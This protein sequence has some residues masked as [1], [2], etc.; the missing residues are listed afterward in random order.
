MFDVGTSPSYIPYFFH[1]GYLLLMMLHQQRPSQPL[2]TP[3]TRSI[4]DQ[5]W[6]GIWK[7]KECHTQHYCVIHFPHAHECCK[8]VPSLEWSP[9]Q[10]AYEIEY[11]TFWS[12]DPQFV[13]DH[14]HYS[15]NFSFFDSAKAISFRALFTLSK[16]H[17]VNDNKVCFLGENDG[18]YCNTHIGAA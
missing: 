2:S 16:I 8:S 4:I 14:H 12:N 13:T 18:T 11:T 5:S 7:E 15:S 10:Y 9:V 3:K 1:S 6:R 17:R